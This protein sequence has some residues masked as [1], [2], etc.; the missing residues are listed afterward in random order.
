MN[1]INNIYFKNDYT[2]GTPIPKVIL[3]YAIKT[4]YKGSLNAYYANELLNNQLKDFFD[5]YPEEL[6][7]IASINW[8]GHNNIT[9][10]EN[11]KYAL[12]ILVKENK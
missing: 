1:K 10:E 9:E 8:T 6:H 5:K 12:E 4:D 7:N 11:K 3:W 2:G